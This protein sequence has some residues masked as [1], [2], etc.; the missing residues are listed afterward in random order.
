MKYKPTFG[1]AIYTEVKKNAKINV[2]DNYLERWAQ[3]FQKL[4]P[5]NNVVF[6]KF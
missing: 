5:N 6:L 2:L 1:P 4:I 3:D